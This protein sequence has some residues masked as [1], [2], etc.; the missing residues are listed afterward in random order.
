MVRVSYGDIDGSYQDIKNSACG[1]NACSVMILVASEVDA[2]ASARM[3]TQQLRSDN[4]AYTLRPV[5]NFSQVQLNR[6][7][8]IT[9]QIKTVFMINCGAAFNIPKLFGLETFAD[10]RVYILDNHRPLHL[11]NIA[12]EENVT[13]FVDE[14]ELDEQ[15]PDYDSDL[16]ASDDSDSDEESA[17]DA[18]N[19]NDNDSDDS[20]EEEMMDD[21]DGGA[22][23][24]AGLSMIGE[25]DEEDDNDD[26]EEGDEVEKSEGGSDNEDE[27]ADADVDTPANEATEDN[28]NDND[29][30]NDNDME[31]NLIPENEPDNK[32]DVDEDE[33]DGLG[34]HSGLGR[35][36]VEDDDE[37]ADGRVFKKRKIDTR[38]EKKKSI[39]S[40]NDQQ[41][42]YAPPTALMMLKLVGGRSGSHLALDLIWQAILGVTDQHQR[43]RLSEVDYEE[44]CETLHLQLADH[45]SSE[46]GKF[47]V[48]DG[49]LEVVVPGAQ[50]G[51]IEEGKDFR[52]FLYRHWSIFEAMCFSPYVAAKLAVWQSHGTGR[53]Q[54]LLAKMGVPLEQCKQSYNFMAPV[55]K[56]HFRRMIVG[57][58]AKDYGFSNPD[59]TCR[60]FFRFNSFKNPVAASDIVHA[61]SALVEVFKTSDEIDEKTMEVSRLQA[62]DEAYDCLGMKAEDK[63]K[64]GLQLSINL[65]RMI[66]RKASGLLEDYLQIMKLKNLYFADLRSG[67][68]SDRA[69]DQSAD[70]KGKG[71]GNTEDNEIDS[72]FSRPMV[73]ARLGQYIMDVK[74]S[75]SKRDHGWV[76]KK[77]LPLVLIG[78][79]RHGK[80][81]VVGISPLQSTIGKYALESHD[82]SSIDRL[83]T[84]CN[85]NNFFRLAARVMAK[86]EN[87]ASYSSST[88]DAHVIELPQEIGPHDFVATLSNS[89]NAVA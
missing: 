35:G 63:L 21:F 3:L 87:L 44:Y 16:E 34:P 17:S 5:A 9:E 2:M 19:D 79:E 42:T 53:L 18:D 69:T 75:M 52:F 6:D 68:G 14:Y 13:C 36:I 26:E 32:E 84:L 4:I 45:L 60:S 65:Q 43:Q 47:T 23:S 25:G 61:A 76:G 86:E 71:K 33:E 48:G 70:A 73:L 57:Q 27:D 40:H 30:D 29:N 66:V 74:M 62:F 37:D 81:L 82:E 12:S 31:T 28:V 78:E 64:K 55:M 1:R 85:F 49:D 59:I 38:K 83:S 80:C 89:L 54:E 72:P 11:A 41:A 8:F 58:V 22:G 46:K 77:L 51:H 67:V 24:G 88:F 7:S 20:E 39:R 56:E 15:V 50:T 10:F